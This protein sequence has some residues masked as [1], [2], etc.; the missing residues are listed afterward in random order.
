MVLEWIDFFG[1]KDNFQSFM[2]VLQYYPTQNVTLTGPVP[3]AEAPLLK[4]TGVSKVRL[5][6]PGMLYDNQW[7]ELLLSDQYT[8]E[9]YA[10]YV[11]KT[12]EDSRPQ[13]QNY[14]RIFDST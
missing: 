10:T 5:A 2:Q 1:Q 14:I 8:P 6:L 3:S 11:Q 9:T 4:K 13:C 12:F 7:S